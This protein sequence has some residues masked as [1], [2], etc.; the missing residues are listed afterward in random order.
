[1]QKLQSIPYRIVYKIN[2]FYN[3]RSFTSNALKFHVYPTP[4]SL[5]R[6]IPSLY[7]NS[8]N[9][10]GKMPFFVAWC[11]RKEQQKMNH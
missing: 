6:K 1:M 8:V 5:R 9:G 4:P 7:L 11:T 10:V 2:C 3:R